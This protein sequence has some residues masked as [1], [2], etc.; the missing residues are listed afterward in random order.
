MVDVGTKAKCAMSAITVAV[1]GKADLTLTLCGPP[2]GTIPHWARLL[3]DRFVLSNDFPE[4]FSG[5]HSARAVVVCVGDA[6][7]S[8]VQKRTAEMRVLAAEG[9]GAGGAR[10]PK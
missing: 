5:A 4:A 10:G 3:S 7:V 6:G 9:S 2:W 1:G 8:M